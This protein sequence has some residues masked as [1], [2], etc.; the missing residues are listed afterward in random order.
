MFARSHEWSATF[1]RD[2]VMPDALSRALVLSGGGAR[3]AYEA[4]VL[5]YLFR[6]LPAELLGERPFQ[7]YCGTSVGAIHACYLAGT[8]HRRRYGTGQLLYLWQS[9]RLQKMLRLGLKDLLSLPLDIRGFFKDGGSPG[10]ILLNSKILEQVVIDQVPWQQIRTNMQRGLFDALT[11]SATHI[12]S[13]KTT[14]FVDRKGGGVPKWSRDSRVHARSARI[15][16]EHA[17][18]SAAIPF[19]FPAISVGDEYYCDGGLRQN[20]P[21]SPALR[22]GANR[23]L[24]VALRSD[25]AVRVR[26]GEGEKDKYPTPVHMMGKIFDALLLDHLDYDLLRLQGFNQLMSDGCEAF[27]PDFVDQINKTAETVRGA[28]YRPVETLVIRPSRDI[29]EMTNEFVES[30]PGIWQGVQGFLFSMLARSDI[31]TESDLMSYLLFDGRFAQALIELGMTDADASRE[32][33]LA[34]FKE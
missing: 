6:E 22:M 33:L 29:G 15:G 34:F 17:L 10:H 25:E 2:S 30:H 24:V 13:G 26:H 9:L 3:G 11:V 31:M 16:P 21:L 4:G 19:L 1:A 7:V 12:A 20:T 5:T 23:V 27:G 8:A 32:Q 14:V 28:S 18:A